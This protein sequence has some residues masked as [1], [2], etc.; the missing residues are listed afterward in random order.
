M[1]LQYSLGSPNFLGATITPNGINFA[2]YSKNAT[3]VELCFFKKPTDK[4]PF[5][6]HVLD[7]ENERFGDVW[8][9]LVSGLGGSA[10]SQKSIFYLYRVDGPFDLELGH[11]F[12]YSQYLLDPYAKALTPG[13]AFRAR[14][15]ED[16]AMFPKCVVIDDNFDWEGDRAPLTPLS[17]SIIYEAHLKG[18]TKSPTSG[19]KNPGTYQGFIQKIP[20]LKQLGV[21]AVEL[22]P[23][24]EFDE[25][26]SD[27]VNP[28]TGESLNN[29]WGYSTL[30]FF[31]PKARYSSCKAADSP[32]N[33]FKQLVK[34]LHKDGI[35]IF[36][37]VVFNHTAEGNERGPTLSFRGL[38]NSVYYLLAQDKQYYMNFSGCGNTFNCAHPVVTKFILDCLRYWVAVMHV[39]GFRFDLATVLGRDE[40]GDYRAD[41]FL[42]EAIDR[43]P[44]LSR[45]KIIAEPW[46]CGGGYL[47]GGFGVS[48]ANSGTRWSEWN[49]RFRN[50]IRR[51]VRGDE[52][53]LTAAATRIAGSSDLYNHSNRRTTASINFI[54]AHDGFTLN[55]LM[56]YNGKHNDENGED[57]RD[58]TND[59]NCYN[60]GFE[61]ITINPK[62][63]RVRLRKLKNAILCLFVS[64]GVPMLL[65][66]DEFRRTQEGNNNAYCQ[67]NETSWINWNLQKKNTE[68]THFVTVLIALRKAHHVFRREHFFSTQI[69]QIDWFDFNGKALEWNKIKRFLGF[70]LYGDR[71]I[72]GD[73][74]ADNDFYI[75]CNT[76]VYDITITLP[77]L[78][79]GKLWH[80]VCDTSIEGDKCALDAGSEELLREQRRYILVA[81]CFV[82]LMSK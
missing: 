81:G 51:F 35:E 24:F 47:V 15:A 34:A 52:S 75:A 62:I 44:I 36:L 11:R 21:T 26:E 2:I 69:T 57:N 28:R 42:L 79:D 58:G 7:P 37:D 73:G 63:E 22:L 18:F 12:D 66:G 68:L 13:S 6:C 19:V 74:N 53:V 29:F 40:L 56:S 55:D 54:T 49:D 71:C 80:L 67:D 77:T 9:V 17:R 70:M 82:I 38:D 20:Y 14:A 78:S 64:Q 32:V 8:C 3:K 39:D 65:A 33:E 27:R 31:A 60:N 1:A 45:A 10:K 72:D 30:A 43:D 61:G 50:D 23:I 16:L 48:K 4:V 59:N 46:D 41:S 25:Y 5:E 76:D